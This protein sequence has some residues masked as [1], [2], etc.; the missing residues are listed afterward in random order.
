MDEMSRGETGAVKLV[1]YQ[2]VK[3]SGA[4]RGRGD[5]GDHGERNRQRRREQ[6]P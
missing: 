6:G 3:G 1:C 2:Q 5:I 4:E